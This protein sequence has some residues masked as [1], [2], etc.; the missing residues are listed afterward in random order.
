MKYLS[1]RDRALR[2]TGAEAVKTPRT[3]TAEPGMV[4]VKL[5]SPLSRRVSSRPPAA[6]VSADSW[7]PLS[8]RAVTVTVSPRSARLG[9]TVT[10]PCPPLVARMG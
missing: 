4:K 1:T 3:S 6:A 8:G 5:P 9:R 7:K 2:M 10:V